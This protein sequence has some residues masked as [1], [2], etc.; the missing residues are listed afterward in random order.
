TC[1]EIFLGH[2]NSPEYQE[3]NFSP[4]GD[5]NVYTFSGYRQGMRPDT[6]FKNLSL[7]ART[8]GDQK[9]RLTADI[10]LDL[11]P[12]A[13]NISAGL[14]AVLEHRNGVK[15]YWAVRHTGERPDFH[16][17]DGWMQI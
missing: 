9:L 10:D 3:F 5:W 2:N 13:S 12:D 1:F 14:S 4:S 17:R 16:A 6:A 11:L 8:E 7:E 15:S